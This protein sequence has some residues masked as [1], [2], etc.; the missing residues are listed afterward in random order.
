MALLTK[1]K[2]VAVRK[3]FPGDGEE[4]QRRMIMADIETPAGLLTVMNGY[5]PQGESRDHETKFP[6]KAKFYADLQQY[7]TTSL[8]PS[9]PVL[10]MGDL[11]ISPTDKDIGIGENNMKR[12][13]KM[14]KCSF[15][16]KSESG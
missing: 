13:L 9:S 1:A 10:I 2:P 15:Y 16:R 3:G 12:W 14:G 7:L 8:T 5:F 4:A 11:N 6:A